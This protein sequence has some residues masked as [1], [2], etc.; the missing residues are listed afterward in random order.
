MRIGELAKLTGTTPRTI[1]YYVQRGLLPAPE[2]RGKDTTYGDEHLR[3]LRAIKRMQ[4][5]RVPLEEIAV[6]LAAGKEDAVPALPAPEAAAPTAPMTSGERWE[7]FAIAPGLTLDL[8][9]HA[10][11]EVRRLAREILTQYG[12]HRST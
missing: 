8:A 12:P 6:R 11:P 7:R 9:E 5:A 10:A 3:R 1:R 2:F 4:E